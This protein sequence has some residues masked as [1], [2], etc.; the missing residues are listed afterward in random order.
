MNATLY[1]LYHSPVD[2]LQD[3]ALGDREEIL[4][5]D[6]V[7]HGVSEDLELR[8]PAAAEHRHVLL[9]NLALRPAGQ[10]PRSVDNLGENV[11]CKYIFNLGLNIFKSK[12][13]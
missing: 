11:L 2:I 8:L 10:D 3:V 9:G 1:C 4:Q 6:D 12:A 5:G 7:V 13:L